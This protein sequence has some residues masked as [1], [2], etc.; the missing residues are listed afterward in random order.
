MTGTPVTAATANPSLRATPTHRAKFARVGSA[1]TV[2]PWV[3]LATSASPEP[4]FVTRPLELTVAL[5][6]DPDFPP[7][8]QRLIE[9]AVHHA[10]A[11]FSLRFGVRPPELPIRYRFPARRFIDVYSNPRD[12]KCASLFRAR[13]RGTGARELTPFRTPAIAFL[14]QW[15]IEDLTR[16]VPDNKRADLQS[17]E[18]LYTYYAGYYVKA[19]D[20][21][22]HLKTPAGT[23]LVEPNKR[24]ERSFVAWL[25]ALARQDAYDVIVTNTFISSDLLSEPYPHSVL[26]KVKVGGVAS[27]SPARSALGGQALMV[28]TFGIDTDIASLSEL[29]G[30]P[31][32]EDTRAQL[33]GKY[34]LAH[35]IAHAVFGIPDVYDHPRGCLMTSRPDTTYRDGLEELAAHPVQCPRCRPYVQARSLFDRG[36]IALEDDRPKLAARLFARAARITPKHFHG[37]RRRWL[38]KVTLGASRAQWALGARK[39]AARYAQ[40]ALRLDPRSPDARSHLGRV[41]LARRDLSVPNPGTSSTATT[42]GH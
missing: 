9:R 11:Q 42:A 29:S 4:E 37:S 10:R 17:Y 34:L 3:M 36:H 21:L 6:E 2:L 20:H 15:N 1:A 28:T 25:C 27:P 19:F 39:K 18:A 5:V 26:G 30:T 41:T 22:A 13:Y 40:L 32:T 23:P 38:S 8:A 31:P 7:L 14:K 35:E 16:F 33:L 12:P 24:L